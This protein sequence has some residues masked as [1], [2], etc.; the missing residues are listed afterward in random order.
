M[1]FSTLLDRMSIPELRTL[2]EQVQTT[3][4]QKQIEQTWVVYQ[5]PPSLPFSGEAAEPAA[6]EAP[7]CAPGGKCC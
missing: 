5:P 6:A 1:D 7:C 3:L 4:R 2:L